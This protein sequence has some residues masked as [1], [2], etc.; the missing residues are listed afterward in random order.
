MAHRAAA[1]KV[2]RSAWGQR[3]RQIQAWVAC[4]CWLKWLR[5]RWFVRLASACL[6]PGRLWRGRVTS[7]LAEVPNGTCLSALKV[8][9]L[10]AKQGVLHA[11]IHALPHQLQPKGKNIE[12]GLHDPPGI[13][14]TLMCDY[15]LAAS[16]LLHFVPSRRHN[17]PFVDIKILVGRRLTSTQISRML[18]ARR[19]KKTP[20]EPAAAT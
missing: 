6:G 16:R 15:G 8:M 4:A 20:S 11:L 19:K 14:F 9:L 5:L 18:P 3:Q 13:D 1:R 17:R 10:P 7:S 2:V 12:V